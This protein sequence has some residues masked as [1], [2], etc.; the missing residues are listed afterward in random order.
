MGY[1]NAVDAAFADY[2]VM[3]SHRGNARVEGQRRLGGVDLA[4]KHLDQDRAEGRA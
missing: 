3:S 1:T 4:L 2:V